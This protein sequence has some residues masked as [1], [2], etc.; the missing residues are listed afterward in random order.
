MRQ[1]VIAAMVAAAAAIAAAPARAATAPPAGIADYSYIQVQRVEWGN[2]RYFGDSAKGNGARFS[3][4]WGQHAFFY[5][6]FDRLSFDNGPGYLYRTGVGLGYAQTQGKVSAY[7]K[8]GYYR[9]RLSGAAGGQRSYYWEFAYGMRAALNQWFSLQGELYTDLH[10][11]FGS[12]PWGVRF[13]AAAAFGPVSLH[14]VEDHNRDVNSL[15][16]SLRFAF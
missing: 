5:G 2:S 13:G 10:P 4:Q 15:R 14:L 8:A 11:E 9:T 3:F 12:R 1:A 7:I 16:A 6:N